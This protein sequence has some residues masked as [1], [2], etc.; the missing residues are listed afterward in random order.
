MQAEGGTL[1]LD[2]IGEM[3]MAM[4]PK[5]LRALEENRVRPVGS[6]QEVPFN[7]RLV[8]ATN[9]DL[10]TEI[11]EGRFRE[12]LYFRINVIPISCLRSSPVAPTSCCSPKLCAEFAKDGQRG[13]GHFGNG[14]RK[15]ADLFLAGKRARIAE[16]H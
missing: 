10:E 12:D 11:E 13:A 6:D 3:P 14:C 7:V 16:R 8:T 2:E 4:Q 5:L 9:R 15:T 1:F